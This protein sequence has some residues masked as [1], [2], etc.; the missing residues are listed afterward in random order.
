MTKDLTLVD[1]QAIAI[2]TAVLLLVW[3]ATLPAPAAVAYEA[4]PTGFVL[5]R[6]LDGIGIRCV[7]AARRS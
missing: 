3:V 1:R 4:E 2:C 6:A 7:V 5:A